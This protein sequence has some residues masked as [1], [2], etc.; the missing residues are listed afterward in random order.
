MSLEQLIHTVSVNLQTSEENVF[1]TLNKI[2]EVVK[3][4]IFPKERLTHYN[5][6][7]LELDKIINELLREKYISK[8]FSYDC[9]HTDSIDFAVSLNEKCEYCGDVLLNSENHIINETF[10]LNSHFLRLIQ[11]HKLKQLN[12]YLIE[13]F[14]PNLER[15]KNDTHRLIPFLG[16]GVSIPFKLPDWS[17]LLLE[18]KTELAELNQ[19][20][21]GDLIS[22]GNYLRAL[23]FLKAYSGLYKN[24]KLIKKEIKNTIKYRYT[25]LHNNNEHN[26][27]DILNLDSQ[28]ILTTNY[29][30]TLSEYL[31]DYTGTFVLPLT[32]RTISDLQD[33]M[34]DDLPKIIHLHGNVDIPDS[35]IVTE[36]DYEELYKDEKIKH[37]LNGIMS[38][39]KL[40]FIGFSFK[41]DY[42]KDLYD[43]IL[44]YIE[45]EHYIILPN[46]HPFDAD[47]LLKRHLIPIG[48][49]V[50]MDDKGDFVK[51]LKIVLEELF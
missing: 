43:K 41:D 48:I 38:N 21:Y 20:K 11:Q 2:V 15:L 13:D 3:N 16:A 17:E 39:K 33:L 7:T 27:M 9:Q 4:E 26:I 36:D 12:S 5:I 1:E 19:Q 32:L 29:D 34:E 18:F 50:N 31:S 8:Y 51:A 45:G 30:N 23:T 35:M 49:N 46:L 44:H 6:D 22:D 10:K 14:K 47:E 42:F 25:K 24:E 28:F 37:I 40:L